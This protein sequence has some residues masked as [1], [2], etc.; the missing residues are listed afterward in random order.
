MQCT[1]DG[2]ISTGPNDEQS[3]VTWALDDIRPTVIG[4]LQSIDTILLGRKLAVDYIPFWEQTARDPNHEMVELARHIVAARKVVF[5]KTLAQSRWENTEVAPGDLVETVGRL[6]AEPGR[7][8]IAYGGSAFVSAL[9]RE[10]LIDEYTFFLN[11]VALGTG[12]SVFRDL[13]RVRPLRLTESRA[14]PSGIV[15]LRYFRG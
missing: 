2:F 11:P 14:F 10:D 8:L 4:L 5:T 3:W 15:L 12:E 6:K 13:P 9:I 7:D 1:L